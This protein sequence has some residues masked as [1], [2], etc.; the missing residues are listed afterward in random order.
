MICPLFCVAES[1]LACEHLAR[2][3]TEKM[4]GGRFELIAEPDFV[5]RYRP[6]RLID[7]T[8]Q[9]FPRRSLASS[10][11]ASGRCLSA[12]AGSCADRGDRRYC[13]H[14]CQMWACKAGLV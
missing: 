12:A 10:R 6:L 9:S 5:L 3:V 14:A 7:A 1:R 13:C 8:R 4:A 11:A 2:H